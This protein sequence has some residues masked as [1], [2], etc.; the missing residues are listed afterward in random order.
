MLKAMQTVSQGAAWVNTIAADRQGRAL[1]ADLSVVPN[2]DEAMLKACASADGQEV[3]TVA[4][5][6]DAGAPDCEWRID[7]RAQQP[8]ILPPEQLPHLVRD[9]YVTNS[10]D[11]YWLSN[12][13]QPLEGYSPIIGPERTERTLRTRA[14]LVFVNEVLQAEGIESIRCAA[15]AGLAVQPSQLRRGA[16][17]R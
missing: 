14:G 7:Q 1:Y 6:S 17:A 16:V 11:S 3:G 12:P 9:D 10:N 8:G 4:G 15:S 5:G 2:V 13:S